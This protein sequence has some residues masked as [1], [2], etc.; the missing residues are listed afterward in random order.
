MSLFVY[1]SCKWSVA[2]SVNPEHRS[3]RGRG[4]ISSPRTVSIKVGW[5]S[6]KHNE[7]LSSTFAAATRG[8]ACGRACMHACVCVCCRHLAPPPSPPPISVVSFKRHSYLSWEVISSFSKFPDCN[9]CNNYQWSQC[10]P[11][12]RCAT[13]HRAGTFDRRRLRTAVYCV[14]S[15]VLS[16]KCSVELCLVCRS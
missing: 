9:T 5:F 7:S 16:G 4:L 12:R 8:C 10:E 1:S 15:R 2:H 11:C 13:S 3:P 6:Q 14:Y